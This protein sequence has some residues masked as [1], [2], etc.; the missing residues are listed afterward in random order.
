MIITESVS[1]VKDL[2]ATAARNKKTVSYRELHEIF[3]DVEFEDPTLKDVDIYDTLEFAC[4]RLVPRDIAIPESLLA[5]K[6]GGLPSKGFFEVFKNHRS[7]KFRDIAGDKI[8]QELDNDE[9]REIVRGE[10]NRVY[11]NI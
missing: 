4:Q 7:D 9:K 5:K 1:A 3:K 8:V 11:E 10:R 6:E 2:F